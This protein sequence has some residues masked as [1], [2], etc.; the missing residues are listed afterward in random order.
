M[1]RTEDN[2]RAGASPIRLRDYQEEAVVAVEAALARGVRRQLLSL[3]TGTGKTCVFTEVIRRR[4]GR[5]LVLVHR[6]ELLQQAIEKL[7]QIGLTDV[8]ILKAERDDHDRPIVVASIQTLS[9]ENRLARVTAN[10]TTIV[11]DEAHHATAASY[12]RVLDYLGAFMPDGPLVLGVS[13][14]C[15]RADGTALGE[16][17]EEIVYEKSLLEMIRRQYLADDLRAI[18]VKLAVD[19]HALHTRGGD[20]IERETEAL[21]LDANAPAHVIRAYQAHAVG[22]KTIVFTPTVKV[23]HAMA[24]AFVAAGIAA[25]AV[26]GET[27]LEDRRATLRRFHLG[28]T[29]VIC[30]V[31]V[32][33]EGYDEPSVDCIIIGKPTKSRPHYMQMIGRATRRF[34][35][36]LDA[37]ILDVV[38]ASTRFDLQTC[39]TLFGL[40]PTGTIEDSVIQAVSDREAVVQAQHVEG[41]LI[42]QRINLFQQHALGWVTVNPSYFILPMGDAGDLRLC[43]ELD[44]WTVAHHHRGGHREVLASGLSIEYAMGVG[45]DAARRLGPAILL[46]RDARWRRDPATA[47][48][49]DLL[50]RWRVRHSPH[51]TKG[52]AT[53]LIAVALAQNGSRV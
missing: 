20:F 6:D 25:E 15:E 43:Q 5:A 26:D 21:L 44:H 35:G 50:R 13:A 11:P 3:P 31:A 38:G 28:E 12:R 17:F 46:A 30:N 27:P 45:E 49:L 22:R 2:M 40:D 7:G 48:Q 33:V 36:K 47:R 18:Q 32:L 34:P 37:L 8:G 52:E 16:I 53:S 4:P 9:R 24:E 42:A 29:R 1:N 10:F 51:V 39:A 23:A 19:Y 41:E 14:T